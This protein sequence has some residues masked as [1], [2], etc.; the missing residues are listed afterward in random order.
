MKYHFSN[1][2]SRD[3]EA[4]KIDNQEMPKSEHFR[5]LGSMISKYGEFGDDVTHRIKVRWLK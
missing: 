5:Y 4:V 1:I 2:R 3:N